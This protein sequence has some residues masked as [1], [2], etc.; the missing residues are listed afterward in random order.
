MQ[1]LLHGNRHAARNGGVSPQLVGRINALLSAEKNI[2]VIK[3]VY[4]FA[5]D[6]YPDGSKASEYV[7]E[8]LTKVSFL[9]EQL[10][11]EPIANTTRGEVEAFVHQRVKKGCDGPVAAVTSFYHAPRCRFLLRKA[12]CGAVT[13]ITARS[14]GLV[15][16]ACEIPK[17][18][19]ECTPAG[20]RFKER[21]QSR[22]PEIA[23]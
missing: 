5:N 7:W 3:R 17:F 6:V 18:A 15:D 22:P 20:Q 19:L 16:L 2:G 11:I 10:T 21:F 14:F 8:Q 12:G 4:F 9:P 13:M 23:A 1:V